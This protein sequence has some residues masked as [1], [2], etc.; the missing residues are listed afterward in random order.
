VYKHFCDVCSKENTGVNA[1]GRMYILPPIKHLEVAIKIEVQFD[2]P[3]VFGNL[4]ERCLMTLLT[5]LVK[6]ERKKFVAGRSHKTRHSKPR[7]TLR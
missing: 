4:H 3:A 6:Q 1:Q 2:D 5:T 7:R